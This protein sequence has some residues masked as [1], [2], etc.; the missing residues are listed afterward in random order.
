MAVAAILLCPAH[1]IVPNPRYI[2]KYDQI[3]QAILVE[4]HPSALEDHAPTAGRAITSVKLQ[5]PLLW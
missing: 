2:T 4:V 1:Y 3:E 5:W